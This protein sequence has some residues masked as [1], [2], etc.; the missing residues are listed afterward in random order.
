MD[1]T[2]QW[3]RR[4]REEALFF[5]DAP[6]RF[7]EQ[8]VLERLADR[9]LRAL[10]LGEGEGRDALWLGRRGWSVT[11]VDGS[12]IGLAK[13]RARARDERLAIEIICADLAVHDPGQARFDL[14]Y[15]CFCHLRPQIRRAV[16]GWAARAL[17]PGGLLLVEGYTP[18]QRERGLKTGGPKD[19]S[20]LFGAEDLR[21]DVAGLLEVVHLEELE[22]YLENGRHRGP[23]EVVRLLARARRLA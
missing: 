2:G 20:L 9:P 21:A 3:D 17:A 23:A 15:A 13:L 14:V 12:S 10:S 11:A 4:Y 1:E 22:A 8:T 5:G 6:N 18:R 16:H 7:L 19:I